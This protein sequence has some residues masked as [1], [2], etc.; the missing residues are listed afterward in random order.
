MSQGPRHNDHVRRL[1]SIKLAY[2]FNMI[3]S[4]SNIGVSIISLHDTDSRRLLQKE[5]YA[6]VARVLLIVRMEPLRKFS[7]CKVANRNN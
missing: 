2:E 3:N 7:A 1:S 4:T 6:N 5:W